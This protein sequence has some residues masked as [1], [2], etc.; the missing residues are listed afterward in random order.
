MRQGKVEDIPIRVEKHISLCAKQSI[1]NIEYNITNLG[2][3]NDE[4]WFGVEFNFSLQ[5]KQLLVAKELN[6]VLVL[7]IVDASSKFEVL[8][9]SSQAA[10]IWCFPIETVSQ[11][12]KGLETNYQGLAV[13]PSWKFSLGPNESWKVKL[14]LKIEE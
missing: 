1:I 2:E 8:L 3:V 5:D 4:F 12:E 9:E 10:L 6:K 7:K 14:S 11:S 13:F